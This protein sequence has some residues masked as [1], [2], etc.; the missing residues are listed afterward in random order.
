MTFYIAGLVIFFGTH[1]FTAFRS[2]APGHDLREKIGF[3][4]YMGLYS[5]AALAGFALI[6]WGFMATRP[7]DILYTAPSW[8]R[9]ANMALML[10]SLV[11]LVSA[12]V[13]TGYI[14]KFAQHPMLA[15]VKI[16]AFG[17]LLAN[18]EL[19]SV[20]LFGAFLVYAVLARIAVK[21]RGDNGPGPDVTPDLLGDIIAVVVGVGVYAALVYGLHL[22]LFGVP[23][24]G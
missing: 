10:I 7:S 15:A 18:G 14:K 22:I 1:V 9:H 2:R 3:G 11:L 19:N 12:Y 21:R 8:G 17:H 24:L 20:L 5:I 4:R 23:V 13:P 16:W 6:I